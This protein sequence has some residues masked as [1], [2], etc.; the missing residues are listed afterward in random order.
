MLKTKI[1]LIIFLIVTA[2][3]IY[4]YSSKNYRIITITNQENLGDIYQ[5]STV[6]EKLQENLKISKEIKSFDYKELDKLEELISNSYLETFII[7]SSNVY[8]ADSLLHLKNIY[9]NRIK[10]I[11]LSHQLIKDHRK[12]VTF[13]NNNGVDFLILP[14]HVI[15]KNF[16]D[17]VKNS[18][19]K[20]ITINGVVHDITILDIKEEYELKKNFF[21]DFNKYLVVI[22]AGDFQNPDGSWVPYKK[23]DALVLAEIIRKRSIEEKMHIIILN[24][25]RTGKHSKNTDLNRES[26]NIKRDNVTR[27]FLDY[28]SS[29]GEIY[30]VYNF[31]Y[32]ENS[33]YKATLGA[34]FSKTGS[35]IWVPAES[36]SNI[37]ESVDLLE[38]VIVYNYDV[39]ND[40]HKKHVK[41]EFDNGRVKIMEK[42]GILKENINSQNIDYIKSAINEIADAIVDLIEV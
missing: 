31:E 22:L 33:Y 1:A 23:E 19:T 21:H 17:F 18:S 8:G 16:S 12:L 26:S 36:T 24:S 35:E 10:S 7:I 15:D 32:G 25:P 20:L 39:V 9:N 3:A 11:H 29:K 38:N 28:L 13:N 40:S 14:S 5:I 34:I 37:S 2:V 42:N 6:A 4:L 41:Q 27:V 30:S